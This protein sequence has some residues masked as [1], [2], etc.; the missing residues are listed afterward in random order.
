MAASM[1]MAR[2]AI[3]MTAGQR[4]TAMRNVTGAVAPAPAR[5]FASCAR[6]EAKGFLGKSSVL[7]AWG[8]S[9]LGVQPQI[10]N[11]IRATD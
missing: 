5:G 2:T 4:Q 7:G 10:R 1:T 6:I 3:R 9:A 11:L 8:K